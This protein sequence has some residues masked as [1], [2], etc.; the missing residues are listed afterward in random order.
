M[1]KRPSSTPMERSGGDPE[2]PLGP[3]FLYW[4]VSRASKLAAQFAEAVCLK[5]SAQPAI[6][7][8]PPK[9]SAAHSIHQLPHAMIDGMS[10]S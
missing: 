3:R 1:A 2:R 9:T 5:R 4:C 8:L 10:G 7:A 6:R